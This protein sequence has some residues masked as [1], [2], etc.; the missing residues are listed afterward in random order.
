MDW[1]FVFTF[2]SLVKHHEAPRLH[3]LINAF[4]HYKESIHLI[5]GLGRRKKNKSNFY[6]FFYFSI[7]E[8]SS[9]VSA[10]KG[11]TKVSRTFSYLRNKMSSSKKSKVS[12]SCDLWNA[13]RQQRWVLCL[14]LCLNFFFFTFFL[15]CFLFF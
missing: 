14:S 9:S 4:V 8:E 3:W 13:H 7:S 6:L 1:H 2:P 5:D 15:P 12:A 10:G 11:V